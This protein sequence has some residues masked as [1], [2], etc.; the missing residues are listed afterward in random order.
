MWWPKRKLA[1]PAVAGVEQV[2][3]EADDDRRERHRQVDDRVHEA[4]AGNAMPHDREAAEDPEDRVQGNGDD[5]DLDRQ[6][7]R[8][9]R[10]G[11]RDRSPERVEAVLE[12]APEDE[13]DRRD[14]NHREIA[15][16][17]VAD[18]RA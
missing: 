6:L 10:V 2:E 4:H 5:G 8:M 9:H 3:R 16:R 14:E 1:E 7:Q 12:R 18:E 13:A 11:A 17:P 15:E